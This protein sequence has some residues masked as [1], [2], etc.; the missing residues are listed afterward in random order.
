MSDESSLFFK[1]DTY[2]ATPYEGP[3]SVM[4][5]AMKMQM[6]RQKTN[7]GSLEGRIQHNQNLEHGTVA[8]NTMPKPLEVSFFP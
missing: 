8:D 3:T 7:T 4:D 5:H 6:S 1:T 2:R